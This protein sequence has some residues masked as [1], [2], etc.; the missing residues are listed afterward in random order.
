MEL[1][2]KKTLGNLLE[3]HEVKTWGEALDWVRRLPYGRNSDRAD[4]S[5]VIQEQKG[6]CSS[7]HAFLKMLAQENDLNDVKLIVG[8]Y[9]MNA[10]NTGRIKG[11]LKKYDVNEI[12]EAHCYLKLNDEYLDLTNPASSYAKIQNFILEEKVVEPSFVIQD[13]I[14]YHKSFLRDW[15]KQTDV[16]YSFDEFWTIREECIKALSTSK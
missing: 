14:E 16:E 3:K 6:S 7:K 8:I 9:R 2:S 12:P 4:F 13:K 15:L 1:D 10:L 5:L 11:V